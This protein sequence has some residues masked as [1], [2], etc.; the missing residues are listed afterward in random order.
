MKL[1]KDKQIDYS[2]NAVFEGQD[3]RIDPENMD[4]L[5]DLLQDPY[6]NPVGAVVREYV[7][8][9]FD[10]H[11]EAAFIKANSISDIRTEFPDYINYS[12][13]EIAEL[14]KHLQVFDDDAVLVTLGKDETGHYWATEDFGVGLSESRVLDVFCS[15]LKSTKESTNSAIGAFGIGSK[16][17]LSYTDV[18]H[19]RTRY[20]G[21]ERTY[22]LR[23]GEKSPRLDNLSADS[24]SERNGTQIKIY[25]KKTK[26]F[27]WSDPEPEVWKFEEECKKQLAYFDNVYFGGIFS[28]NLVNNYKIIEGENWIKNTAVTPFS[29]TH[30]CLGKVAYPIDWDNLGIEKLYSGIALKFEIG[31]LDIIQ[32]REDVKY[33][34]RTKDA[35]IQKIENFKNEI[36]NK[37]NEQ[38]NCGIENNFSNYLVNKDNCNFIKFDAGDLNIELDIENIFSEEK[39]K[40][41]FN[42]KYESFEKLGFDAEGITNQSFF[43]HFTIPSYVNESGLKHRDESVYSRLFDGKFP[44]YRIEGPHEAKK[45]KYIV[46]KLEN[47]KILLLRKKKPSLVNY[48][49]YFHLDR[50]P[51]NEW[52]DIIKAIQKAAKSAI[53]ERTNSY[54][55]VVI[56]KEWLKS[57]YK[58]RKSLDSSKFNI[59]KWLSGFGTVHFHYG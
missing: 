8:N 30:L 51:K 44:I 34:P 32:T 54:Q 26:Q 11:A 28:G 50:Y 2:S 33:T 38:Y 36:E 37:W 9:S 40:S 46:T 15:Y 10:S 31:E 18:I 24:T 20:N 3:A 56:D 25:I 22:M 16:S 55:K 7:S 14:K 47:Q 57:T 29:G 48:V 39:I 53:F 49:K 1:K 27:S 43:I 17:G 45:S 6:K 42:L 58:K 52:R 4:K 5:W 19:I 13:D 41:N 12:D 23:K 35:I 21:T 59:Y